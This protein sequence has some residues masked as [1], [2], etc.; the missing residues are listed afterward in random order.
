MPRR[1]A[2]LLVA[3]LCGC[4][5]FEPAHDQRITPPSSYEVWWSRTEACS[6]LS[7]DFASVQWFTVPGYSFDCPTGKCVGR[8]EGRH[9]IYLAADWMHDALRVRR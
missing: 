4:G 2:W 3:L 9:K 8:W 7:G 1:V 6:G 5:S